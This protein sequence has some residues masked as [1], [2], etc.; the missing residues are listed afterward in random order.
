ML[1]SNINSGTGIDAIDIWIYLRTLIALQT[2][3][4]KQS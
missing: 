4:N 1:L 2:V 3:N